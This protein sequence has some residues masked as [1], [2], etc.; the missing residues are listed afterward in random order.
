MLETANC[1]VAEFRMEGQFLGWEGDRTDHPKYFKLAVPIG[2]VRVKLAKNLR[3]GLGLILRPGDRI[4]V[5]GVRKYNTRKQ[6]LKLKVH[7]VILCTER[8]Q[9]SSDFSVAYAPAKSKILVCQKSGC[10]KRGGKKLCQ[11]LEHALGDR[12]LADRVEIQHTGCLKRCSRGPN[13]MVM[14]GKK[15][16]SQLQPEAIVNFLENCL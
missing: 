6:E 11:A 5:I 13:L 10:V 8:D 3:A 2:S 14:P 12:G 15:H 1:H 7:R 4:Q 16:F 9:H